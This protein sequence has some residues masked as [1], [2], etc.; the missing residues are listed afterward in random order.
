MDIIN[1]MLIIYAILVILVVRVVMM[2]LHVLLVKLIELLMLILIYVSVLM[3]IFKTVQTYVSHV[4]THAQNVLHL[5][6]HAQLAKLL[7]YY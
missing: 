1:Q 6:Q 4:F 2:L 3:D 5:Q 7:I